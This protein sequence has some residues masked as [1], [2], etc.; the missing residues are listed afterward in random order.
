MLLETCAIQNIDTVRFQQSLP[1][2][3]PESDRTQVME[4][5]KAEQK[6]K[7]WVNRHGK[8]HRLEFKMP[9]I[10]DEHYFSQR[11]LSAACST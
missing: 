9:G 11:H 1:Q 8:G 3:L 2:S 10:N 6:P 4:Q 5:R 7:L